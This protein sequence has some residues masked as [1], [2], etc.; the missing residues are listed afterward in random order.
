[1]KLQRIFD[2]SILCKDLVKI[3]RYSLGNFM[4]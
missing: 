1:M 2:V 3:L 4:R